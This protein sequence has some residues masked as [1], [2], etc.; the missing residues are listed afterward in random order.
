M[1]SPEAFLLLQKMQDALLSEP[2][3]TRVFIVQTIDSGHRFLML[4]RVIEENL[5]YDALMELAVVGKVKSIGVN[6]WM[7]T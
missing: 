3:S 6:R 1:L 4:K 7:L 2:N 5:D